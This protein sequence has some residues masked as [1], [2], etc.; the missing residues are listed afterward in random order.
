M[1]T[2][3]K[4]YNR[5]YTENKGGGFGKFVLFSLVLI[6]VF[7]VCQHALAQHGALALKVDQCL[8][9]NGTIGTWQRSSDNRIALLCKVDDS[10]WGVKVNKDNGDNIT[11]FVQE[12]KGNMGKIVQY[13][14][15]AGYKAVDSAAQMFE[16][17]Y[18]P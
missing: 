13:F 16:S 1:C 6:I 9:N 17:N 12:I 2:A 18:V 11:A 4:V 10:H 3:E 5:T 15:N 7:A 8:Q 14:R